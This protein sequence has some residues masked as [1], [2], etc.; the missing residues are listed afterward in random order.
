[1]SVVLQI[2][3][4]FGH[5]FLGQTS[6]NAE[7]SLIQLVARGKKQGYAVGDLVN[8]TLTSDNQGAIESIV[9]R[10]NLFYRSEF[11]KQ[12]NLAANIDQ[13]AIV[14][15]TEPAFSE[16]LLGRALICAQV[17][18]I[19]A[20]ILLNKVDVADKVDA[21]RA[22]LSLYPT[23]G[24]DVYELSAHK[25]ESVSKLTSL[26]AGKSTL[27]M[28][29]SGM[30]KSSLINAL[31]PDANIKTREI[32]SVLNS[33]KHTTTFSRLYHCTFDGQSST[34]IDSPGFENFGMAQFSVSQIQHAMLEFVPYFGQCK[35]HNCSHRHE[36]Q[37]A[38]L[39]AMNEG[40]IHPTRHAFYERLLEQL[41]Y[42][43]RAA[44]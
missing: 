30:G 25:S 3:A 14:C 22:T 2:I 27:L 9:P 20:I 15:A 24:Y 32:S 38:V 35:F 10:T 23:L 31:I 12:K 21:A 39:N 5:Q 34:I 18:D 7:A 26:L 41:D 16:E 43:D 40:H 13:V 44:Y 29:Q 6:D 37:C 42:Y 33:G 19:K 36:P 4:N 17:T 1:M 8:V 28:G 11:N